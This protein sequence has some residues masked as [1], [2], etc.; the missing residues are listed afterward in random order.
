MKGKLREKEE[1]IEQLRATQNQ[2][3]DLNDLWCANDNADEDL[4][5][6]HVIC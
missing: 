3:S 2:K 4:Q 5:V 6:V 1:E